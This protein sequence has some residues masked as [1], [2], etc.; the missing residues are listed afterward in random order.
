[1][2]HR[3]KRHRINRPKDHRIALLR[4]QARELVEH[5]SIVTTVSKA[6]AL[7]VFFDKLMS[8]AV[9]AAETDD[10]IKSMNTRRQINRHLNDRRLTNKFVD[11]IAS[12]FVGRKGGYTRIIR[13][14]YRRGD[15]AE[16]ALIQLAESEKEE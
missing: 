13:I 8:K 10:K 11:E 4:N 12:R 15:G 2:R 5:G 7:K 14:G 3:V 9:K 1:M 6:K 16:M